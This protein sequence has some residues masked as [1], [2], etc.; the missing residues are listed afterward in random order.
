MPARWLQREID[1]TRASAQPAY[2]A[3]LC[4]ADLPPLPGEEP[5][6]AAEPVGASD[7]AD[8]FGV[9]AGDLKPNRVDSTAVFALASSFS[10]CFGPLGQVRICARVA[11]TSV[12]GRR[13][14][15]S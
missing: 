3:R 8:D 9:G 6:A 10:A 5:G 13:C 4:E 11:S 1:R 7:Q 15:A 12:S 14:T 2:R